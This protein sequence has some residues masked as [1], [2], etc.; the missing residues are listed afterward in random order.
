M[1]IPRGKIASTFSFSVVLSLCLLVVSAPGAEYKV[2]RVVDGDTIKVRG[3]SGEMTIRLSGIDAPEEPRK[4]REAGQ[5]FS[6]QATKHLA[7]LVLNKNVEIKEYGHDRHGRIL[8]VVSLDGK[9][10]NLEMVKAGYAEVYRGDPARGLDIAPY[11][12]AEEQARAADKGMWS[13]GDKYVSP[14]EWRRMQ[15]G[16]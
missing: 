3:A 5:P 7:G 8:G 12:K 14:R 4:K 11:W 1:R 9:D 15:G 6:Q 2:S 13:L 10:I 16:K